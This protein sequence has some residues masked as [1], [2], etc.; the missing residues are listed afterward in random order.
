MITLEKFDRATT[1]KIHLFIQILY[2]KKK[3]KENKRRR[4]MRW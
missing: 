2:L 1:D 4:L 3:E